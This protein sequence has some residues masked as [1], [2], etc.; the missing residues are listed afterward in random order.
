VALLQVNVSQAQQQ[1]GRADAYL[2]LE[3]S[4]S[5]AAATVQ[6]TARCLV[7]AAGAELQCHLELLQSTELVVTLGHML[8]IA[9]LAPSALQ[10][11][12]VLAGSSEE[13]REVLAGQRELGQQLMKGLLGPGE[14]QEGDELSVQQQAVAVHVLCMC[15]A[16]VMGSAC[17]QLAVV[18]APGMCAGLVQL[19]GLA[20]ARDKPQ[21]VVAV[22]QVVRAMVLDNAE[23]QL[24]LAQVPGLCSALAQLLSSGSG[25]V[26]GEAAET[27]GALQHDCTG[28]RVA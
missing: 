16:F 25:D 27:L 8:R 22:V 9:S 26:E 14:G 10:L 19:L 7:K 13:V 18:Q 6:C 23:A 11:L 2:S 15:C 28:A 4:T 20:R 3:A 17:T 12:E 5:P 24:V 1:E 21:V